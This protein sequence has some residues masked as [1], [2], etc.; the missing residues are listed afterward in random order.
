MEIDW[1]SPDY[2]GAIN[3]RLS[4]LQKARADGSIIPLVEYYRDHPVEFINEWGMTSDPRRA[5]TGQPTVIPFCLFPRQREFISEVVDCWKSRRDL[6]VEKSRDMGVTWCCVG[7]AVWIWLYHPGAVVGFGSRKEMLVDDSGNPD[8]IFWKIRFFISNLPEEFLPEGFDAK[9]HMTY[10]KVLHPKGGAITGE[11]GDNIG[12][13]GRSSLHFLDEFAYVERQDMVDA[14]LSQTTNC[15]IY[16]STPAGEADLFARKRFGGKLKVFVFDWRQDPR[17]GDEW[18]RMQKATSDAT[19]LAREVDR[20]YSAARGDVW[21]PGDLVAQAQSLGPGDIDASGRWVISIDAA[22]FGDDE[23]VIHSRKGR[24]NLPQITGQGWDGEAIAG[25]TLGQ[26]RALGGDIHAIIIEMDGPGVSCF[27]RLKRSKYSEQVV[28]VHTGARQKDDKN[29]NLRAK[30]FSRA[31]TYLMEGGVSLPPDPDLK[32]QLASIGYTYRDGLLLI[33]S[34]ADIKKRY[35]KSPD[36]AMAFVLSF[37]AEGLIEKPART[38]QATSF[39][40]LDSVAGY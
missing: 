38:F 28:G 4:R 39:G 12:R 34:L 5:G 8:S 19:V 1:K 3:W 23:S 26:C 17:K 7:I 22:H 35:G 16:V 30:L 24:L 32:T 9:T 11:A 21:I 33:Q 6:V 10:M 31:K 20:D 15:R 18:Y 14:A 13:G 36:R 27:D 40:V 2:D 37:G 25:H 29:Y